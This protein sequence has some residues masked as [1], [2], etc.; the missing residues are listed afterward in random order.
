MYDHIDH[1]RVVRVRAVTESWQQRLVGSG[2]L[3]SRTRH[4]QTYRSTLGLSH[5]TD[6]DNCTVRHRMQS[7]TALARK[8]I[9]TDMG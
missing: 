5:M 4:C 9:R 7:D 2:V 1:T 6:R 8:G 3:V